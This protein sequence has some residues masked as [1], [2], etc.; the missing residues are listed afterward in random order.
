VLEEY[1]TTGVNTNSKAATTMLFSRL[2]VRKTNQFQII[3][4]F[5]AAGAVWPRTEQASIAVETCFYIFQ[6]SGST[7]TCPRNLYDLKVS[8]SI[9]PR[10][11][12]KIMFH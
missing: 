5:Y 2:A 1:I 4:Y 8:T 10:R 12:L 7:I 3:L 9:K 6:V 11:L